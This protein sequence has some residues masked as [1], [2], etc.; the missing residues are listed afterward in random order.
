MTFETSISELQADRYE[1][2]K[3]VAV[4]HAIESAA[5]CEPDV[6]LVPANMVGVLP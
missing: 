6:V 4:Q 3:I 2:A 1:A 5:A